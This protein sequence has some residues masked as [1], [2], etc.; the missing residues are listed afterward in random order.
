MLIIQWLPSTRRKSLPNHSASKLFIG[1][2]F[3]IFQYFTCFF[4]ILQK[5]LCIIYVLILQYFNFKNLCSEFGIKYWQIHILG[6]YEIIE[7]ITIPDVLPDVSDIIITILYG[8]IR[9]IHFHDIIEPG[10][11]YFFAKVTS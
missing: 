3:P 8:H 5:A 10:C 11:G 1:I 6:G 7:K 4:S 9:S 2:T